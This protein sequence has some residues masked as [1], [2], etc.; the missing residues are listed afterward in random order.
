MQSKG[1]KW[2]EG[3]RK[4]RK[5]KKEGMNKGNRKEGKNRKRKKCRGRRRGKKICCI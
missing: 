3:R 2:E 1:K 4:I 5:G